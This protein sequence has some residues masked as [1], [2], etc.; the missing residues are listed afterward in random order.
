M[1]DVSGQSVTMT[2]TVSHEGLSA[3]S[4]YDLVVNVTAGLGL[5]V[6]GTTLWSFAGPIAPGES[7]T[8][9]FTGEVTPDL[10]LGA[11]PIT[12]AF[13][14]DY[15][16]SQDTT[17]PRSGA[18][19]Q[20]QGLTSLQAVSGCTVGWTLV[21]TSDAYTTPLSSVTLNET[22]SY[23][24]AVTV[25]NAKTRLIL[26]IQHGGVT[27]G[28]VSAVLYT[29]QKSA[30]LKCEKELPFLPDWTTD[31]FTID[32]GICSGGGTVDIS[33]QIIVSGNALK[34]GDV[35]TS[36]VTVTHSAADIV[37][38]ANI[39]ASTS[40][41]V[42]EPTMKPVLGP[43][44][45][46]VFMGSSDPLTYSIRLSQSFAHNVA[47][48]VSLSANV[49]LSSGKDATDIQVTDLAGGQ[50][51]GFTVSSNETGAGGATVLTLLLGS[52][53][54]NEDIEIVLSPRLVAST[55]QIIY[56]NGATSGFEMCFAL[57][58]FGAG[59]QRSQP[60]HVSNPDS[61]IKKL[62]PL[63]IYD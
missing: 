30:S 4:A 52:V 48:V 27:S 47:V 44:D 8:K 6:Q 41:V 57:S 54:A 53:Y 16:S 63:L 2:I 42:L 3:V 1:I 35:L 50:G 49:A 9:T 18:T 40:I 7:F 38:L 13:V 29:P 5:I 46:H 51:K 43:A 22:V 14:V 36:Q 61:V 62:N 21:A 39:S 15:S 25:P 60:T 59:G 24:A 23:A 12:A 32:Y 34:Q 45:L 56:P 20:F 19:R 17:G 11:S 26:Y 10:V 55:S 28:Q 31:T 33:A 58:T 37:A